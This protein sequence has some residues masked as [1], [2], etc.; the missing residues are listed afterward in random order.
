LASARSRMAARRR[1]SR[2]ARST[3][4]R[5]RRPATLRGG[6]R[7]RGTPTVAPRPRCRCRRARSTPLWSRSE[8]STQ[9]GG[10]REPD[11]RCSS[12]QQEIVSALI[13]VQ[14]RVSRAIGV[15]AL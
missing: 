10:R 5:R 12:R 4:G 8:P 9:F 2:S 14:V 6:R 13:A 11:G 1:R 7:A 3:S 15:P